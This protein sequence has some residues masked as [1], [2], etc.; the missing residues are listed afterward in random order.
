MSARLLLAGAAVIALAA[1]CSTQTAEEQ[2]R[3]DARGPVPQPAPAT[4]GVSEM[5]DLF[6]DEAETRM[7]FG[8]VSGGALSRSR[9][10]LAA[11]PDAMAP[12]APPPQP[13]PG[14]IDRD[15][16]PDEEPNPIKLV[17]EEPVSTFSVDV[18][19]AAYANVRR[20]L[21][22]GV[23][24]P[25]DAVRVEEIVNYFD[26]DYPLPDD[27][28]QP[29][30]VSTTVS[31]S[32]WNPDTHLLHVGLK[33]YDIEPDE[34]PN[35]NLVFLLDVSGSMD[36]P[37]KL[38]LVKQ[39]MRLIVDQMTEDDRVSIVVY[40]GAAGAVLEPTPGDERRKIRAALDQ[41]SAGGS[42]AGGEGMR[43]A[44]ALAEENFDPDAINRVILAT[45]GDFNVGVTDSER[46]EDF[47]AKK[48]ESGVYLSVLGFG[49]GNYQDARMQ[50]ISQ[51]GDGTA[52]YIDTLR[53]ARK[54]L[55]D[56][57]QSALF[58][59]ADDVKIQVE[60]NPA[61]VAEYRLIGYETRMLRREDFSNDQVDAGEIGAGHEVTAIYEFA[62]P[63]SAG[64]LIE[65]S[66][67][68][69]APE[70]AGE[71]SDEFAFLRIR[72][73]LPGEDQSKLIERPVTDADAVG[74]VDAAP[75]EMR[76]AAAAAGFA[77]LLRAEPYLKDFGFDDVVDL[78]QSAKGEDAFG[79]RAEFI[80]LARLAESAE[81]LPELESPIAAR[82][83]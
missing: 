24:P 47:V 45:D 62:A 15:T 57:M 12:P 33:G 72:Y 21:N 11:A 52:A 14:D 36:S 64:R 2:A 25:T 41:L 71:A 79:Y 58:P 61:R 63:D 23:A 44:Y 50:T 37:D 46:L 48:R 5:A 29:F 75:R 51:A 7:E 1:A 53:E 55:H 22:D 34:R 56:E 82:P 60:F 80:Q 69:A 9:N 35:A 42:T 43:L 54:V 81:G 10:R 26:Y 59:I 17:A 49:R 68:A 70:P 83:N 65:P 13:L 30:S 67:Y 74:D 4:E 8:A 27:R 3:K 78:A 76:F 19:T 66:R 40:A 77:Q 31:P 6:A 38:P 73:K 39:A 28:A 20:Y 18:D 32:P 16:Y